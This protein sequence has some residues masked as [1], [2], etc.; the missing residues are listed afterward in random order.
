MPAGVAEIVTDE[1]DDDVNPGV[2]ITLF[3]P[4]ETNIDTIREDTSA[5]TERVRERA[6]DPDRNAGS[7]IREAIQA[8]EEELSDSE[9]AEAFRQASNTTSSSVTATLEIR[10]SEPDVRG[11]L[12]QVLA[13]CLELCICGAS[14]ISGTIEIEITSSILVC[15]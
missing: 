5:A 10:T 7:R 8:T 13:L 2:D 3:Y 6:A 12:C 11:E 1:S 4:R 9:D 15:E 14:N